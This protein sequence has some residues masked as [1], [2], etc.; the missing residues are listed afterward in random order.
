ML[1]HLKDQRISLER[2]R[3]E[4]DSKQSLVCFTLQPRKSVGFHWITQRY[5]PDDTALRYVKRKQIRN[6]G[7]KE[8]HSNNHICVYK[9]RHENPQLCS[10][11][12]CIELMKHRTA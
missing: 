1:P 8:S 4:S 12:E 5:I 9:L 11:S 3:N 2:N 10:P 7:L 6:S